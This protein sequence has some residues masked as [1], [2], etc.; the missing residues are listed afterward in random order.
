MSLAARVLRRGLVTIHGEGDIVGFH[1]QF[2]GVTVHAHGTVH[3]ATPFSFAASN[4]SF[5]FCF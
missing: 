3:I 1:F 2:F 5:V 4:S